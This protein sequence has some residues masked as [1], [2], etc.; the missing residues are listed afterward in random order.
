MLKKFKSF[1]NE[2]NIP[3]EYDEN[4]VVK[5]IKRIESVIAEKEELF[6]DGAGDQLEEP[7]DASIAEHMDDI[8][9]DLRLSKPDFVEVI[10]R[11]RNTKHLKHYVHLLEWYLRPQPEKSRNLLLADIAEVLHRKNLSKDQL[12]SILKF[13]KEI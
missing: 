6:D 13:V 10:K 11:A 5:F 8:D 7:D 3:V 9:G 12:Q 4:K 1:I 2:Q